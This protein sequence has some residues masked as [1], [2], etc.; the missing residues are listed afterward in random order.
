M[1]KMVR[2]C[3][4]LA[5]VCVLYC[6][7]VM[8]TKAAGTAF[9]FIWLVLA[10]F[11]A[12][13]ALGLEKDIFSHWHW[14][15][16]TA[17]LCVLGVGIAAFC[18]V[19][20]L[21]LSHFSEKGEKGLPYIIVL[22][23]QMKESGPSTTLARRLD[24]AVSYLEENPDTLCVVSGGQGASEPVT[25]ASGMRD[26]LLR[27]GIDDARILLEERSQNTQQNLEFSRRLIPA[28]I[29]KAGIVTSNFHVYRGVR[30]A[31]SQGFPEAV[32]IAAPSSLFFLPNNML[33]EFFGVVKDR[34]FGN[35]RLAG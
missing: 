11:F 35:M 13:A 28:K 33:R 8:L 10:A 20:G 26:Y 14:M 5:G 17:V 23:A 9:Y 25:E 1:K 12:C 32:G 18:L 15:A 16:R 4:I 30:L 22:G 27:K 31:K 19:E 6:I 29:Q 3:W 21:V 7:G 2:I 34:V 24:A